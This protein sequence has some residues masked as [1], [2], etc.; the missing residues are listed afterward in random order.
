MKKWIK[1]LGITLLIFVIVIIISAIWLFKEAFGPKERTVTII[2]S[3]GSRLICK[4]TYTADMAAVFYDVDFTLKKVN[5]DAVYL[6][7]A[8]FNN[9]EWQKYVHYKDYGDCH[10]FYANSKLFM[11][12]PKTNMRLDTLFSPLEL[13][14]DSLWNQ[15][16]DDIPS[17]PYSGN[18][19]IDTLVGQ[20]LKVSYH[21]R[22]GDY[23]PFKFYLQTIDYKL[24]TA[25]G[26]IKTL[27]VNNRVETKNGS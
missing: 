14:Y 4:E 23:P 3:N 6:G 24:D 2:N 25:A 9:E 15:V 21:Y 1:R 10:L 27:K 17:W 26:Q 18:A 20:I 11:T 5:G 7:T 8:T 13:R 12:N 16:H 22:I 19:N